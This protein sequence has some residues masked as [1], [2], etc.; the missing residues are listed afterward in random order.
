MRLVSYSWKP[1]ITGAMLRL[2]AIRV[3]ESIAALV[4]L[5]MAVIAIVDMAK[6]PLEISVAPLS[7]PEGLNRFI[8]R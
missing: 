3:P 4:I 5:E 8:E 1:A 7:I 6:K 2:F